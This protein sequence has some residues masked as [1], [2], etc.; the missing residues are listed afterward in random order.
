MKEI[1]TYVIFCTLTLISPSYNNNNT[2]LLFSNLTESNI[3]FNENEKRENELYR[4]KKNNLLFSFITICI[5]IL[6]LLLLCFIL[7]FYQT[8]KKKKETQLL[9]IQQQLAQNIFLINRYNKQLTKNKAAL[10]NE[11]NTHKDQQAYLHEKIENTIKVNQEIENKNKTLNLQIDKLEKK[12][13]RQSVIYKTIEELKLTEKDIQEIKAFKLYKKLKKSPSYI[14]LSTQESWELLFYWC[15]IIHNN[16]II[17]LKETFPDFK[18]RDLKICCL[19]RMG[20]NNKEMASIFNISS[21]S[22]STDKTRARKRTNIAD[23]R[24]IDEIISKL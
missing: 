14:L 8:Y 7:F 2:L 20:F 10:Q 4:P 16:F 24:S 21:T 18:E 19:I 23:K 11:T 9:A 22:L 15:N 6:L 3:V 13:N 1:Y 17:H 5:I 12:L